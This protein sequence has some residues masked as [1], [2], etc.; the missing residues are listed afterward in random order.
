MPRDGRPPKPTSL[1]VLH[2][3]RES[4]INRREPVPGGEVDP[5]EWLTSEALADWQRLAPD[6]LAKGVLTSWDVDAFGLFCEALVLARAEVDAHRAGGSQT[7]LVRA[8]G[9][10]SS[11]GSRFG[12]TPS[13]RARLVMQGAS[14]EV[15]ARLLS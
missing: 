14:E 12:W 2:G 7:R 8:V 10:V 13:D 3:V 6:R 5:P 9:L 1:K 4:R 11:L 15:A